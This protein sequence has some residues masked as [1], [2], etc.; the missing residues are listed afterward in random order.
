M[1]DLGRTVV[2]C[3]AKE[4]VAISERDLHQKWPAAE[5]AQ[6]CGETDRRHL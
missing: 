5:A 4:P 6:Y 1:R 2:G 3:L